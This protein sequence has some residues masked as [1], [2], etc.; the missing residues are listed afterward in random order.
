MILCG[1]A[2]LM[3]FYVNKSINY[4]RSEVA[5]KFD[6]EQ[7]NNMVTEKKIDEYI[8]DHNQILAMEN[9]K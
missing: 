8:N 9:A 7:K 3:N 4:S 6:K 2:F 5:E 1:T